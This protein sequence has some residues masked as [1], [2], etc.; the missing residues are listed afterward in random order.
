MNLELAAACKVDVDTCIWHVSSVARY[1]RILAGRVK[2]EH[3]DWSTNDTLR[4]MVAHA[5]FDHYR[6]RFRYRVG[7][8]YSETK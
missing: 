2:S 4:G 8:G 6:A 5:P 1:G 3:A 7:V